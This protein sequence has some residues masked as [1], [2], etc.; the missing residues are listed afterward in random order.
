[1]SFWNQEE[2]MVSSW[3][4]RNKVFINIFCNVRIEDIVLIYSNRNGKIQRG[5]ARKYK[6]GE[7]LG[8]RRIL[9]VFLS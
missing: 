1:V 6:I 5:F 8:S 9:K 7:M 4:D 3:R 2:I